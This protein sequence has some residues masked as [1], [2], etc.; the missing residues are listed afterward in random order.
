MIRI[1]LRVALCFA[2]CLASEARA[3]TVLTFT[4]LRDLEE[5]LNYYNGGTGSLGSA[6]FNYGVGFA[7]GAIAVVDSDVG[8]TGNFANS[9]S[10]FTVLFTTTGLL[11]F[12]VPAGF[13]EALTFYYVTYAGGTPGSVRIFDGL[14]SSGQQLG[15]ATLNPINALC[16]GDPQGSYYGCWQMVS[17]PVSGTARSVEF[18]IAAMQFGLDNIALTLPAIE[19]LSVVLNAEAVPEPATWMLFGSALIAAGFYARRTRI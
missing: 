19:G 4:G 16:P 6:A 13:T 2:F 8:G 12:N 15:S 3:T 17:I 18:N 9:P 5:P 10:P 14:N 1:D 7:P 11:S